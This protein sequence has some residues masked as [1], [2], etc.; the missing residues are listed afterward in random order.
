MEGFL[1]VQLEET[2]CLKWDTGQ[3]K[4][5]VYNVG[6]FIMETATEYEKTSRKIPG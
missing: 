6:E 5:E 4:R 2:A 1:S 3:G